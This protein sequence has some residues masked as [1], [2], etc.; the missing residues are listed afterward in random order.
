MEDRMN[1]GT[2]CAFDFETSGE[3]PEFSLQPW[4]VAQGK[5]WPTS[6]AWVRYADGKPLVKGGV[7]DDETMPEA[8]RL[9]RARAMATELLED[10]IE[11]K[12]TLGGWFSTFDVSWLLALGLE[13]LVAKVR[14]ADGLLLWRH[15]FIE[16]EYETDR[17]KKRPYGLKTFVV[18]NL[19]E[20]AGYDDEIDFHD[21]SV[22]TRADLHRYNVRDCIA[23][24]AGIR[25]L[26]DRLSERQ[27]VAAAIEAQ[28]IPLAAAANLM[29]L[30]VDV[31]ATR[32]LQASLHVT[33]ARCLDELSPFGVTEKVVRSPKQLGDLL[34]DQW[35]LPILKENTGKKTGK[36]SRATD[37]EV[38]HELAFKDPR[39]RTLHHYREALGN[40]TKF[41][42]N[43]LA[44]V[45]YN[46]DG[47]THPLMNI[48]STYSGRATYSSQQGKNKAAR[49][50]GFALHQEKR[51]KLF[52]SVLIP[53]E[54][55]DLAEFD[56]AGQE[57]RWMAIQSGDESMMAMCLPGE[58]IHSFMGSR[59]EGS[60]YKEMIDRVRAHD[61]NAES[62]RKLGKVTNLALAYRT[63]AR[64]LRVKARVDYDIPME[65]PQAE[66]I[67]AVYLAT[68]P[69]I[70]AY[71]RSSIAKTKRLGYAETLA[72]RRVRVQGNW[73]GNEA[74]S[75]EGSAI[76]YP[77]QGT[78]A[79]QKYLALAVLRSY[80]DA[81]RIKFA[82]E[83]HDGL[84]FFIPKAKTAKAMPT[85]KKMLDTLPY[86]R[87]W[88][89][90]PPIPMPFDA[91][92]GGSWGALQDWRE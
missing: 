3:L 87:A 80:L 60:D 63:S 18:E 81:E 28:S 17:A 1:L 42:D 49:P 5:A 79:D 53:P 15:F 40:C 54:D 50:I 32:E 13:D 84:F 65:L 72:G 2:L 44:S 30:P 51:G 59:I 14:F 22:E 56:A 35:G 9:D 19:P 26:W 73:A 76:N 74:W 83:L 62:A 25:L 41:A 82:F 92:V 71:W 37:K 21:R 90:T 47:R 86:Q 75:M 91:K 66:H 7:L 4:R 10:A 29:G 67:R 45:A 55:Y 61:Y 77:I 85:I 12:L 23:T 52:R 36:I 64:R 33:A 88:G 48:F 57:A 24:Y 11:H 68:Y 43:I 39:A 8:E 69:G 70:P 20:F 16:P 58:D 46:E 34:Y 27:Q 89:L 6:L 78:G 38:L 31:L